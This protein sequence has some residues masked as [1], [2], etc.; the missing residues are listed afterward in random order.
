M[1]QYAIRYQV[2]RIV[3]EIRL[4]DDKAWQARKRFR[5]MVGNTTKIISV[6]PV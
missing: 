6:K 3:H 4:F 5:A 2:G 1:K